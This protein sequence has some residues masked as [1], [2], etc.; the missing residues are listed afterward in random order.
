MALTTRQKRRLSEVSKMI[1]SSIGIRDDMQEIQL[2]YAAEIDKVIEMIRQEKS[3][4]KQL[5]QSSTDLSLYE[6]NTQSNSKKSQGSTNESQSEPNFEPPKINDGVEAPEW[7]KHLWKAIAKKCHPD[8]LSFQELTAIEIARRQTWFLEA[9]TLYE[10]RSWNKL[11]HIGVQVGE[12][13]EDLSA[14]EQLGMLNKE[15]SLIT[16]KVEDIQ[17][18]LAWKWG[19][20][21]DN[22][23][24]RLK[25]ITVCLQ[26]KGVKVPSK[27]DLIKILVN[28]EID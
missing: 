20:N 11:I 10:E 6:E 7:A 16:G 19:T 14:S 24:L 5:G 18:S 9:R 4:P 12:Y 22:L 25:I 15:Y 17:K 23:E 27:I 28:L 3:E 2:E 21:W 1:E 8:R 13:V 26:S